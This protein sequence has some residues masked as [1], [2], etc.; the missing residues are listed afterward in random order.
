MS[1]YIKSYTDK[2][3]KNE[4]MYENLRFI[5]SYNFM[6]SPL[7]KLVEH[8]PEEKFFLLESYFAELG[9]SAEQINLLN[10]KVSICILTLIVLQSFVNFNYHLKDCGA[11]LCKEGM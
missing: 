7:S 4:E 9:H 8:L 5:D 6:L 2:N 11:T 10:K 3:G 1:V